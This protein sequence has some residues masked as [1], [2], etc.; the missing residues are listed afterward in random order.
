M[1]KSRVEA[2]PDS[3]APK[4]WERVPTPP[5]MESRAMA[6]M[7]TEAD[8]EPMLLET[9][10]WYKGVLGPLFEGRYGPGRVL[11]DAEC[12]RGAGKAQYTACCFW[13][14][15]QAGLKD[16]VL[17]WPAGSVVVMQCLGKREI[18]NGQAYTMW[19]TWL[20]VRAEGGAEQTVEMA[21][22]GKSLP[23]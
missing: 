3:F 20:I 6:H 7:D 11:I 18:D 2:E 21:S 12:G 16:T 1:G 15:S 13:V 17:S 22:D 4:A 14:P 10:W 9:G 23:F 8:P 19:R 5:G